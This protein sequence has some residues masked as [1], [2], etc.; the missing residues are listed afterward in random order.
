MGNKDSKIDFKKFASN[1][2]SVVKKSASEAGKAVQT[3][4]E[5]ASKTVN[6][7][8]KRLFKLLMK[9][10]MERLTLKM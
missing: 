10:A 1:T 4:T 3:V 6:S 8:Q 7:A 9:M 5:G 2:A